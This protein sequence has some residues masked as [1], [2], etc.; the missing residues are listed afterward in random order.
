MIKN[1]VQL[2]TRFSLFLL[3]LWRQTWTSSA[4]GADQSASINLIGS[5]DQPQRGL[6]CLF[7]V[8]SFSSTLKSFF[9]FLLHS[10]WSFA[11]F[12]AK[13]IYLTSS[14]SY[15]VAVQSRNSRV[16][17]TFLGCWNFYRYANCD[18]WSKNTIYLQDKFQGW[19]VQDLFT[20]PGWSYKGIK[21]LICSISVY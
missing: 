9:F 19:P 10:A 21:S 1:Y 4:S 15:F 13:P 7:W 8:Y 6:W 2:G 17:A 5:K 20:W 16:T 12:P 14:S 11:R 18:C 3:H